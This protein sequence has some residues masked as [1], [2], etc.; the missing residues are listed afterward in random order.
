MHVHVY[1]GAVLLPVCSCAALQ[2][3]VV[4]LCHCSEP[5]C[6]PSFP[7]HYSMYLPQ[8]VRHVLSQ[9]Y[10]P[11]CFRSGTFCSCVHA[12]WR[13]YASIPILGM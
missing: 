7:M 13:P 3:Q 2:V 10:T 11:V 6:E 5:P 8:A 12:F 1:V 4:D 9:Y